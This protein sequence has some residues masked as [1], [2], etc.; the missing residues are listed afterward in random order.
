MISI[1]ISSYKSNYFNDVS[2][3]INETIGIPYEIIKIENPGKYGMCEAYNM[4]AKKAQYDFLCFMHEDI[5]M[6]TQGWGL[7]LINH[8]K[9]DPKLGLLGVAGGIYKTALPTGWFHYRSDYSRVNMVQHEKDGSKTPNCTR[10]NEVL[11]KVKTLDGMFLF[12]T[13][14]VWMKYQFNESLK[15]FHLYDI[16]FSLRVGQSYDVAVCYDV[17]LEHFS[18][19]TYT[20]D[21]LIDTIAYHQH[22][23]HLFDEDEGDNHLI[24]TCWYYF[25]MFDNKFSLSNR[26]KYTKAL[27]IDKK[28]AP[29][30]LTFL[31]PKILGPFFKL[32]ISL[33]SP[34]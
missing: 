14:V 12:T 30:A 34:R 28:S 16:D 25:L 7:K 17:T 15:G 32:L 21:W 11:D 8:F 13:K 23:K 1:I 20:N 24:R 2:A 19:G 3:N 4:G 33:K 22:N 6:L 29:F 9:I 18:K 31:F 5:K 10:T 26:F 27:G